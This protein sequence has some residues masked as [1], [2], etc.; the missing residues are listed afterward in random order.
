MLEQNANRDQ[1]MSREMKGLEH[2]SRNDLAHILSHLLLNKRRIDR[3]IE[4]NEELTG[5]EWEICQLGIKLAMKATLHLQRVRWIEDQ[6]ADAFVAT[7]KQV[8]ANFER[9]RSTCMRQIHSALHL[10][11]EAADLVGGA[12]P[13]VSPA[14]KLRQSPNAGVHLEL[15]ETMEALRDELEVVRKV[16]QFLNEDLIGSEFDY[17]NEAVSE[18]PSEEDRLRI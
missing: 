8:Y 2:V 14:P 16:N 4:L 13:P 15:L 1:W 5:E 12:G 9:E 10:L 11:R 3:R 18:V 17:L 6:L 7:D